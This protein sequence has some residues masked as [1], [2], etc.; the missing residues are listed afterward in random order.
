MY[1]DRTSPRAHPARHDNTLVKTRPSGSRNTPD[2]AAHENQD[3]PGGQ[4]TEKKGFANQYG[5]P[6]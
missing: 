3:A 4:R 5:R 6:Q 2:I 1:C